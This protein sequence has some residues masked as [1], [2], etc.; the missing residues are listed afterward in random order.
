MRT[1]CTTDVLIHVNGVGTYHSKD[2]LF[3]ARVQKS[4]HAMSKCESAVVTS[5][6]A[7]PMLFLMSIGR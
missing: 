6:H 1:E 2:A 4:R 7:M 5:C 3:Y